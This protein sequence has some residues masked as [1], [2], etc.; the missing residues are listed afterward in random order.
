ML[1]RCST[2]VVTSRGAP[3]EVAAAV[4]QLDDHI[5]DASLIE[6]LE[7]VAVAI[8]PDVVAEFGALQLDDQRLYVAR[9]VNECREER[10]GWQYA[11]A[12]GDG[13]G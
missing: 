3:D 13:D 9:R 8:E 5:V 1:D 10:I 6:I 4:V 7:A 11:V 2:E 12:A